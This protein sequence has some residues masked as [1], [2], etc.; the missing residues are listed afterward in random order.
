MKSLFKIF[1]LFLIFF[2]PKIS[3]ATGDTIPGDTATK[4]DLWD[5]RNPDCP[6]HQYQKLADD[7]YKRLQ[8]QHRND[9]L[10]KIG[11]VLQNNQNDSIGNHNTTTSNANSTKHTS[12]SKSH[13]KKISKELRKSKLLRVRK[14]SG[15]KWK[16]GHLIDCGRF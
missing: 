10:N 13:L 7:E 15:K 6:C 4:Y 8:E 14:T 11:V 1:F 16:K 2:S 12:H 9:S 3:F 5:P